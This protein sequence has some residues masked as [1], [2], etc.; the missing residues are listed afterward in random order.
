MNRIRNTCASRRAFTLIELLVVMA[1]I[2][3]LAGLL[4]PAV[5]S[6]RATARQTECL[7]NVRQ[8]ALAVKA[9]ETMHGQYP[10]NLIGPGPGPVSGI[11]GKGY[12]SW[13]VPVLPLM[14]GDNLQNQFDLK[15]NHGDANG[16]KVSAAHTNAAAA[17]TLVNGLL[18]PSDFPNTENAVILGTSNPAPGSYAGNAG[19]PSYATGVSGER[20][21]PGQFN[22][23]I[24]LVHPSSS[25]PWHLNRGVRAK[26][27][28]DG[29]THTALLSERLIQG[30]NSAADINQGDPRLKSFHILERYETLEQINQ[31]FFS[32]HSHVFEA[33]HVGRSWS[34]GTPLVAPTYMHVT[35]PN[36]LSGHYSTSVAEGDLVIAASSRH[37][38]G[39]TIGLCDGS[40]RFISD[41]I[42]KVVWWAL[43]SRN[44]GRTFSLD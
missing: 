27:I 22:G 7:N 14:E 44:D 23:V 42:D 18:C 20:P 10:V 5:Q 41:N 30:G 11:W 19:W 16:Y 15:H 31:Q 29:E 6:I 39:V 38:G 12:Y 17:S 28:T 25:V 36:G 3:V 1:V 8:I 43:G 4:F 26:D 40:N 32:T 9:Y 34:S 35:P 24:S 13:L 33:A 2:G 21:T 37:S